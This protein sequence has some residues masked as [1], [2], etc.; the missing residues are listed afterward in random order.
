MANQADLS[1]TNGRVVTAN[2]IEHVDLSVADG[3]IAALSRPGE[4]RARATIDA[5]G[6]LVL[7]GIVDSHVHVRDPGQMCVRR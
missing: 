5:A 7:P 6:R 2:G 1:I 3:R 4:V